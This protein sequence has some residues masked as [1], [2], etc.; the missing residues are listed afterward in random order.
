MNCPECSLPW[1]S[2]DEY[3]DGLEVELE[4]MTVRELL[5][6][7]IAPPAELVDVDHATPA[8]SCPSCSF[9]CTADPL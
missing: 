3:E 5:L 2:D 8:L 7:M 6:V 1:E 9:W 4:R